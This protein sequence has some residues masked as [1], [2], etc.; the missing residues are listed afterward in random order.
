[1]PL[2][3]TCTMI[4]APHT[5]P[6]HFG[7]NSLLWA[8]RAW[9]MTPVRKTENCKK[10]WKRGCHKESSNQRQENQ[11]LANSR[12]SGHEQCAIWEHL[13]WRISP[14]EGLGKMGTQIAHPISSPQ[15]GGNFEGVSG[16]FWSWVRRILSTG[17]NCGWNLH[18]TVWPRKWTWKHS[19]DLQGRKAATVGVGPKAHPEDHGCHFSGF[20]R[21][22]ACGLFA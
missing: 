6:L 15:K 7:E 17:C 12:V 11:N 2:W 10:W 8:W 3:S 19:G 1:M 13:T 9:M 16:T 22:N 4:L 20:T 14:E 21:S 5:P 18:S